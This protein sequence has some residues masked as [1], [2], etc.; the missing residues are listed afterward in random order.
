MD[1]PATLRTLLASAAILATV[2]PA[3]AADQALLG[4]ALVIKGSPTPEGR[5]ISLRARET[6]TPDP[7]VGNPV[8]T[9]ALLTISATGTSPSTD[10]YA[11]PPGR[12]S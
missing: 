11:L 7:L 10:T 5:A 1:T 6:L 3:P 12:S 9:G 4:R 2:L 8:L